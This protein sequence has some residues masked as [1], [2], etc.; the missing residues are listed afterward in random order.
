MRSHGKKDELPCIYLKVVNSY[1]KW[2]S[3]VR[4]V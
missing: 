1:K 4:M 2:Y 3:N